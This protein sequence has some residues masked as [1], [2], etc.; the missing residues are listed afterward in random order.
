MAR[1]TEAYLRRTLDAADRKAADPRR[2]WGERTRAAEKARQLRAELSRHL[3]AL[4]GTHA[5][6][7]GPRKGRKRRH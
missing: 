2:S 5:P 6:P 3:S 4:H 1:R 7:R